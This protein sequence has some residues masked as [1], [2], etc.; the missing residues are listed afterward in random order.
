[1]TRSVNH[2]GITVGDLER[3]LDFYARVLGGTTVGVWER[4]GPRIDA[5]TG[6]RGVVVRQAFVRLPLGVALVEL[7][8]YVG[9]STVVTDPDHGRAGSVHLAV[10]VEGLDEVLER[11]RTEGVPILS[12]PITAGEGPLEGRRVVYV[13]DPDR[14]RVELV[15]VPDPSAPRP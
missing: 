8:Q 3:S 15:E 7:L 5:V 10:D 1:M 9:G 6:Y 4:S 14:V 2:V 11:M 13:L 12:E